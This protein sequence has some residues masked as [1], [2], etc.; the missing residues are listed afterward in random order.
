MDAS[1]AAPKTK[2]ESNR[3]MTPVR[4]YERVSSPGGPG[5]AMSEPIGAVSML[6]VD[7]SSP[8]LAFSAVGPAMLR[9]Y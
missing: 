6:R 8:S 1:S 4:P 3:P 2:R 7:A 5:T 9:G